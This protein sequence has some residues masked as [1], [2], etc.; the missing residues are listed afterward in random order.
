MIS[1]PQTRTKPSRSASPQRASQSVSPSVAHSNPRDG[2]NSPTASCNPDTLC[3]I[4]VSHLASDTKHQKLATI[5][6]SSNPRHHLTGQAPALKLTGSN[7]HTFPYRHHSYADISNSA[8]LLPGRDRSILRVVCWRARLACCCHW[9]LAG[10]REGL[11]TCQKS[12]WSLDPKDLP[13][14][15]ALWTPSGAAHGFTKSR[16]SWTVVVVKVNILAAWHA[17]S[18][19]THKP[20]QP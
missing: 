7:P 4:V 20:A 2:K 10:H 5:P 6:S 12:A 3:N 19:A 1:S 14:H 9:D 8:M 11:H 16:C 18:I 13:Q 17:L 15:R